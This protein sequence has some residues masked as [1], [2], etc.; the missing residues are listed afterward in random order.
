MVEQL[1]LQTADLDLVALATLEVPDRVVLGQGGVVELKAE[2]VGT[3]TARIFIIAKASL[4]IV[5]VLAAEPVIVARFTI[6]RVVAILAVHSVGA[7]AAEALVVT[8]F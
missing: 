6:Q 3:A 5:L 8:T 1:G 7:A 2:A 4:Q